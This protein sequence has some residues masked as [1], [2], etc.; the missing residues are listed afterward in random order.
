MQFLLEP[1]ALCQST[2]H[3]MQY[4]GL[5]CGR[6]PFLPQSHVRQ[7]NSEIMQI[8]G[9]KGERLGWRENRK[10]T[11]Y[12]ARGSPSFLAAL[13]LD[14]ACAHDLPFTT[15]SSHLLVINCDLKEK[16]GIACSRYWTNLIW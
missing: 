1:A 12:F 15:L 5:E 7:A 3:G 13:P 14:P 6:V 10:R 16:K 8:R 11:F 2:L 9:K 4:I